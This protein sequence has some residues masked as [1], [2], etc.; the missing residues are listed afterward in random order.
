[1]LIP[2]S[3]LLGIFA[4]YWEVGRVKTRLAETIGAAAA[5]E[6]HRACVITL[7]R[8]FY[9][10]ADRCVL[11]YSPSDR[12]AEF[13]RFAEENWE[14]IPQATGDLG[15]RMSQFFARA[16]AS[17]AT[18][19]LLTGSDSPTLPTS[20]VY[21]A[22][23]R[24]GEHDVVL[25]PTAD[26]GYYLIGMRL[27]LESAFSGIHWSTD[28]VFRQTRERLQKHGASVF[29]LPLWYDVDEWEDLKRLSRDLSTI[30]NPE[31]DLLQAVVQ[32]SV[33]L[34]SD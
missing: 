16:F 15:Q 9:R 18:R 26:G 7:T 5:A 2:P 30:S 8:R 20:Y 33:K 25:G 19:V 28:R 34:H 27:H 32:K 1:M 23:E 17:G 13:G 10:S 11:A 14:P 12:K 29:E 21:E 24:L 22:F 4:K 6:F 3:T 31:F